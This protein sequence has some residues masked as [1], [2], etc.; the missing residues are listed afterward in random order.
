MK[1]PLNIKQLRPFLYL[2]DEAGQ[3]TGYLVIG[4]KKACVIDTMNGH[5][6]LN[7]AVRQITDL[8]LIVINT[9]WHWDHICGNIFFEGSYIHPIDRKIAEE[10]TSTPDFLKW[11]D[12]KG[13]KMPPFHDLEAGQEVDLGGKT[14]QPILLPGHTPGS[15]LLLLKEDRILFTGDAINHHLWMQLD[16]CLTLEEYIKKLDQVMYLEEKADFILHGHASGPDDISLIRCLRN[17]LQE[18]C[19]GKTQ[20]DKPYTWS[21]GTAVQHN[22]TTA[23]GKTYERDDNVIVYLPEHIR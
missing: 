12:E 2:M 21:G 17:G 13:R 1:N 19:D 3:A 10:Y 11:L 9:H 4:E 6:D 18:I 23:E 22:F 5:N 15:I 16:G 20:E 7:A 14:L 8:P